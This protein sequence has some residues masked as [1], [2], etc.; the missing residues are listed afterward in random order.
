MK[1]MKQVI[2]ET[3]YVGQPALDTAMMRPGISPT[4]NSSE[5]CLRPV[6]SLVSIS[7]VLICIDDYC[8]LLISDKEIETLINVKY[9]KSRIHRAN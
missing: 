7:I 2:K 4:R 5:G 9:L 3:P 6:I 8:L 1:K